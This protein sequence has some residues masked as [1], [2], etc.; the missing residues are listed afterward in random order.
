MIDNYSISQ[1]TLMLFDK[2]CLSYKEIE[3]SALEAMESGHMSSEFPILF[4]DKSP[5]RK[6]EIE[7]DIL[8]YIT[9]NIRAYLDMHNVKQGQVDDIKL[10]YWFGMY[11]Y[12]KKDTAY[13]IAYIVENII[14]IIEK[15][16]DKKVDRCMIDKIIE[17]S[18]LNFNERANSIIRDET[19]DDVH[20]ALLDEIK[21]SAD[22][23]LDDSIEKEEEL[24]REHFDNIQKIIK[25]S[26]TKTIDD[27][28]VNRIIELAKTNPFLHN[29]GRLGLYNT[30]KSIYKNLIN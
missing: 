13:G 26:T 11:I 27:K 30:L 9:E 19:G 14:D 22:F 17:L 28:I 23:I 3:P 10:Y 24:I 20:E 15:S 8:G 1:Q 2:I 6:L 18:A 21:K 7:K 12:E 4:T 29:Y 16:T 5:D 25:D